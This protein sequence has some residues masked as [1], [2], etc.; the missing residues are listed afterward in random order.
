MG[1]HSSNVIKWLKLKINL[2]L[3]KII[4]KIIN[5]V[6]QIKLHSNFSEKLKF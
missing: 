2:A 5:Y 3:L 6:E 1:N 4:K